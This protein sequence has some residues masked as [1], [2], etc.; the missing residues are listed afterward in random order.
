MHAAIVCKWERSQALATPAEPKKQ[1]SKYQD[2]VQALLFTLNFF[3]YCASLRVSRL[4]V[5]RSL[6]LVRFIGAL[7]TLVHS[8]A[9]TLKPLLWALLL[10]LCLKILKEFRNLRNEAM[11]GLWPRL[12]LIQYTFAILFTDAALDYISSAPEGDAK[13][14]EMHHWYGSVFDSTTTLFRSLLGQTWPDLVKWSHELSHESHVLEFS[15]MKRGIAKSL[16]D[17]AMQV[18]WTGRHQRMPCGHWVSSGPLGCG[19]M[20]CWDFARKSLES[21]SKNVYRMKAAWK[22][23]FVPFHQ[24]EQCNT[25]HRN[26]CIGRGQRHIDGLPI[27]IGLKIIFHEQHKLN[28]D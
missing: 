13:A 20:N 6:S 5:L 7:R 10:L 22:G 4:Q 16:D 14:E 11:E 19:A 24:H 26:W 23:H 1:I 27:Q 21:L 25:C 9:D 8:I 2:D 15:S 17:F 18:D 28:V 3:N 12:I